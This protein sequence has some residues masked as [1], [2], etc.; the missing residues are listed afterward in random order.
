MALF[1]LETLNVPLLPKRQIQ[2]HEPRVK[3]P[4]W[5]VLNRYFWSQFSKFPYLYF[6][7]PD[8]FICCYSN[9]NYSSPAPR[10]AQNMWTHPFSPSSWAQDQWCPLSS[11]KIWSLPV[12]V[13]SLLPHHSHSYRFASPFVPVS[14]PVL[15]YSFLLCSY[16]NSYWIMNLIFPPDSPA[17]RTQLWLLFIVL[18]PSVLSARPSTGDALNKS[19][20]PSGFW[21]SLL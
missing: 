21:F 4:L 18:V 9:M 17:P 7:Y 6:T 20:I 12:E 10:V 2:T 14:L 15:H 3:G 5:S 1:W 13:T 19:L 8:W 16:N 11:M